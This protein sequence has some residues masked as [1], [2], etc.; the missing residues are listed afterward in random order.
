MSELNIMSENRV[1]NIRKN[2]IMLENR[3]SSERGYKP[4]AS[5]GFQKEW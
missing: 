3:I 2:N 5:S 1:Y 4:L